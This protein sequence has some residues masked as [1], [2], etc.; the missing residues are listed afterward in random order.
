MRFVPSAIL[1]FLLLSTCVAFQ[2]SSANHSSGIDVRGKVKQE[3]G[4]QPVRKATVQLAGAGNTY[5][6]TTDG[7]GAFTVEGVQTGKYTVTVDHSGLVQSHD[8]GQPEDAVSVEGGHGITPLTLH[9][10]AAG[11]IVGKIIDADGDPIQRR[12]HC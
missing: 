6:A 4:G 8:R 7:D 10:Q 12:C 1:L 5:S 9:M 11:V 2:S 3:P